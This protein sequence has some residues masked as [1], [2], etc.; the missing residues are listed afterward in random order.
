[1][2][3]IGQVVTTKAKYDVQFNITE[4][5]SGSKDNDAGRK[6]DWETE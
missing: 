5:S 6:I 1:M 3:E 2:Q 4:E